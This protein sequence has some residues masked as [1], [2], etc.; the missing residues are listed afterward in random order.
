MFRR[1]LKLEFHGSRI[2]SKAGLPASR[3]RDE[4]LGRIDP[5]SPSRIIPFGWIMMPPTKGEHER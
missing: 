1:H 4:G 3:E 5:I 2:T